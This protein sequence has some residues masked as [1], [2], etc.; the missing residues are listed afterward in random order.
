MAQHGLPILF[1]LVV[2]WVSTGAILY[3]D[4]LPRRTFR[5]SM[6]GATVL[7]LAAL[8]GLAATRG[9]NTIAGAYIAFTCAVVIWGWQ[10]VGFLLGYITGPR[11]APCPPGATEWQRFGLAVQTIMYHELALLVLAVAVFGIAW[12]APNPVGAWTFAVLLVMRLSAKLNLF[13]GVRNWSDE[14]LPPHLAYLQTYFQRRP[15]NLLFPVAVTAATVVAALLWAEA[16]GPHSSPFDATALTFAGTLLALAVL[17]H[18]FLVIPMPTTALWSWGL[19]SREAA[20]P[21][22]L[23]AVASLAPALLV[24]KPDGR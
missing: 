23:G 11:Q 20:R 7:L 9:D 4:G 13:L 24:N 15:M 8:Y 17:E 5:W 21:R 12:D 22:D 16:L 2:W 6:A 10:E 14:L 18:W 1:T 19:R 3:L